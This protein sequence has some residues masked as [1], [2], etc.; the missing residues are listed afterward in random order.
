MRKMV[1]IFIFVQ[2][3]TEQNLCDFAAGFTKPD[4]NN[5]ASAEILDA[6]IGSH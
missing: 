1:T 4:Q 5:K 2:K 6:E 3:T